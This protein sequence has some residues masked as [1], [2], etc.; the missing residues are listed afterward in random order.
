M[1]EAGGTVDLPIGVGRSASFFERVNLSAVA[2]APPSAKFA[3]STSLY[4]FTA[5]SSSLK[6]TVPKATPAGTY[7]I[8]ITGLNWVANA[9]RRR[10]SP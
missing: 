1:G 5:K 6:V 3:G 7:T 8:R 9:R 4:G 2:E 10:R